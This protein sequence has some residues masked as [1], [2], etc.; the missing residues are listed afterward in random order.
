VAWLTVVA[1]GFLLVTLVGL[2]VL[3]GTLGHSLHALVI[4]REARP[5]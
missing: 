5:S 4:H 2:Q 3:S 1:F